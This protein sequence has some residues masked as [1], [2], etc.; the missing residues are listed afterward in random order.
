M[1]DGTTFNM[2]TAY[3]GDWRM[4]KEDV[5]EI[6]IE[7]DQIFPHENWPGA[8]NISNDV[9][10]LKVP[11]ISRQVKNKTKWAIACLPQ[12]DVTLG[13]ACHVSGWGTTKPDGETSNKKREAA[14]NVMT[15]DY[16]NDPA[17]SNMENYVVPN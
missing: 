4:E 17:N 15:A 11:K 1:G 12:K 3:V 2:A 6:S 16:C 5:G 13:A 9:C 14:I 7:T 10:L 8:N